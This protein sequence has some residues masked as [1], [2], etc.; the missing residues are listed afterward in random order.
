[1]VSHRLFPTL[2]AVSSYNLSESLS[3]CPKLAKGD[4]VA[5]GEGRPVSQVAPPRMSRILFVSVAFGPYAMGAASS[6]H[7]TPYC[8]HAV[9]IEVIIVFICSG[10]SLLPASIVLESPFLVL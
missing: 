1:M 5:C 7:S 9:I 4:S 6:V 2:L 3:H 8:L 10:V